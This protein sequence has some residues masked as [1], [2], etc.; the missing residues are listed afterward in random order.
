MERGQAEAYRRRVRRLPFRVEG[1][2]TAAEAVQV[3]SRDPNQSCVDRYLHGVLRD[4]E[5]WRA[6]FSLRTYFDLQIR[7]RA[8]RIRMPHL[9]PVEKHVLEGRPCKRLPVERWLRELDVLFLLGDGG[10]GKTTVMQELRRRFAL[11]ARHVDSGRACIPVYLS[12][13]G[14]RLPPEAD[15]FRVVLR[16]LRIA[17]RSMGVRLSTAR[18]RA[19]L[20]QRR[21]LFLFDGLNEV[22]D[23]LHEPWL[24]ALGEFKD[25]PETSRQRHKLVFTSRVHNLNL[26]KVRRSLTAN[27]LE[28]ERL[29]TRQAVEAF[30]Q[31]YTGDE[32]LTRD[33][34]EQ[35]WQ[36]QASRSMAQVP[37]LLTLM[38]L[39]YQQNP[40]RRAI[41]QSRALVLRTILEGLLGHWGLPG[42]ERRHPLEDKLAAASRLAHAMRTEGLA[43]RWEDACRIVGGSEA[44]SLLNELCSNR[45]LERTREGVFFRLH[46]FQEYLAALQLVE[47]WREGQ[48]P[49]QPVAQAF[50]REIADVRWHEILSIAVGLVEVSEPAAAR[51]FLAGLG[52]RQ[53]LLAAM[54]LSNLRQ[55]PE[56]LV[57]E[58]ARRWGQS[59]WRF[60][61]TWPSAGFLGEYILPVLLLVPLFAY[62]EDLQIACRDL[63]AWLTA[64][65]RALLAGLPTWPIFLMIPILIIGAAKGAE[66]VGAW[67]RV[68]SEHLIEGVFADSVVQPALR[69]L[70]LIGSPHGYAE[71]GRL[72]GLL[73]EGKA[74][75]S[76]RGRAL[77]VNALLIIDD[78]LEALDDPNLR[79][80]A[81]LQLG[82]LRDPRALGALLELATGA[83]LTHALLA[84]TALARLAEVCDCDSPERARIVACLQGVL[85][86]SRASWKKRKRAHAALRALGCEPPAPRLLR[87]LLA[88]L[89]RRP[90]GWAAV[91]LLFGL[92]FAIIQAV[93]G[94]Q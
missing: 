3:L 16:L 43:L 80:G 22:P 18:L 31:A 93:V 52:R 40:A 2:A 57:A 58:H 42:L 50:A 5:A 75:Q 83:N 13:R 36:N 81:I 34:L 71:L 44:G 19:L 72:Q 56:D 65:G 76:Q 41:P 70:L 87:H 92:V 63:F 4:V 17:F 45:V 79:A 60:I 67:L 26:A 9:R 53:R 48:R 47:R 8:D 86:G 20:A 73:S 12:L 37:G 35:I 7:E 10:A 28:V 90:L 32:A 82:E 46:P 59:I 88:G 21:F 69:A 74:W 38:I 91:V 15:G 66:K 94:R 25:H 30:V 29:A 1:A 14:Q 27:L 84:I 6:R 62:R 61:D 49:G 54:C 85:E 68:L 39:A 89:V 24:R 23:G 51:D 64:P 33:V 55:M 11:P 77:V 78:P